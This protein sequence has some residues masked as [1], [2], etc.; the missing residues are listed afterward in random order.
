MMF[1]IIKKPEFIVNLLLH[2]IILFTILSIKYIR[3]KTKNISNSKTSHT[4]T[5]SIGE[6][7]NTIINNN[8]NKDKT[9]TEIYDISAKSYKEV[10]VY[11]KGLFNTVIIANIILWI[12]IIII[13]LIFKFSCDAKLNMTHIITDNIVVFTAICIFEYIFF[14]KIALNYS[15]VLPSFISNETI[16]TLQATVN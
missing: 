15:P 14:K 4:I 13:I 2:G 6:Q 8:L 3:K 5:T 10:D 7:F 1:S 9:K 16:K 12:T 11:N